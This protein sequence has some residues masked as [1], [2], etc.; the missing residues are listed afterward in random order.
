MINFPSYF[1]KGVQYT[2]LDRRRSKTRLP[3]GLRSLNVREMFNPAVDLL[4]AP[5]WRT[6]Q[7]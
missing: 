5:R 2:M 1:N 7:I 3:V 4:S 6:V